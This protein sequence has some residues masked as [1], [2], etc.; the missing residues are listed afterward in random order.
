VEKLDRYSWLILAAGRILTQK[1]SG[2]RMNKPSLLVRPRTFALLGGP[3]WIAWHFYYIFSGIDYRAL[4][5]SIFI[6]AVAVLLM[7]VTVYRLLGSSHISSPGKAGAMGL[8]VGMGLWI[9]GAIL[10]GFGACW[11]WLIAIAGEMVTTL[12]LAGLG[13]GALAEEPRPLWKWLPLFLAPV[14]F[15]SWTTTAE[16]F[17]SWASEYAPEWFGV[18]YGTGWILLGILLP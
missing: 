7:A 13:L 11:A 18:L 9:A 3:A 17:P 5:A 1:S 12:G 15:I 4:G 16:S 6:P 14:Y 8:L 2:G 10:S